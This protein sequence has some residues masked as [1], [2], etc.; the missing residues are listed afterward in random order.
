MNTLEI[1][2]IESALKKYLPKENDLRKKLFESMEYSLMA[3]GKRIRPQLVLE[4]CRI[5]GGNPAQAMPFA[6]ALEMVHSYSLIHDDLP[7]MDDDDLRR[8]KPTNHKVYGEATALLQV[9]RC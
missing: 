9:T 7:C 2:E 1:Q 8:G 6:C 3:G 4:F 5:C